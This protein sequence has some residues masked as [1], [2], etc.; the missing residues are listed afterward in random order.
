MA[1][2]KGKI[3]KLPSKFYGANKYTVVWGGHAI[4][5]YSS[6]KAAANALKKIVKHNSTR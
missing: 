2:R 5:I 6:R 4:D 3:I 1:S